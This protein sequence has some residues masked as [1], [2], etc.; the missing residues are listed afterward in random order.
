MTLVHICGLLQLCLMWCFKE[1]N[2]KD[3]WKELP[4]DWL[5]GLNIAKQVSQLSPPHDI[6]LFSVCIFSADTHKPTHIFTFIH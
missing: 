1:Q 6:E 4:E 5:E 3:V 2:Y